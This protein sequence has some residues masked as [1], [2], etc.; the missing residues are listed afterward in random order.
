M[1][2][3]II[4]TLVKEGKYIKFTNANGKLQSANANFPDLPEE[5][6]GKELTAFQEGPKLVEVIWEDR[7]YKPLVQKQVTQ[8]QTQNNRPHQYGGKQQPRNTGNQYQ[9]PPTRDHARAPYN[10]VPLPGIKKPVPLPDIHPERLRAQDRYLPGLLSG[11]IS[12]ELK[13]LTH[14]FFGGQHEA[15]NKTFILNGKAVIPSATLRGLL[16]NAVA[17]VSHGKFGPVDEQ[18]RFYF[19]TNPYDKNQVSYT[20]QAGILKYEDGRYVIYPT[21]FSSEGPHLNFKSMGVYGPS[22]VIENIQYGRWRHGS[23]FIVKPYSNQNKIWRIHAPGVGTK[24]IELTQQDRDTFADD[25]DL[26]STSFPGQDSF[27]EYMNLIACARSSAFHQ[28]VPVFFIQEPVTQRIFIGNTK[29]F[30]LPFSQSLG[31]LIPQ[32]FRMNAANGLDFAEGLFGTLDGPEGKALRGRIRVEN[33]YGPAENELEQPKNLGILLSPKPSAVQMYLEQPQGVRTPKNR[34]R[35]YNSDGSK[36]RGRKLYHHRLF[37]DS[38]EEPDYFTPGTN[39]M[40]KNLN[41]IQTIKPHALFRARI[42]FMNL[43]PEELGALLFVLDLPEGFAHKLGMG[44]PLGLGSFSIQDMKLNIWKTE[45][46]YAQVFSEN[47]E[48]AS[49]EAEDQSTSVRIYKTTFEQFILKEIK[50]QHQ[51][52]WETD[53]MQHYAAILD[54]KDKNTPDW[55]DETSYMG[56]AMKPETDKEHADKQLWKDKAVLPHALYVKNPGAEPNPNSYA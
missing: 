23:D 1:I 49:P 32:N 38:G 19:R 43:L 15:T 53:M 16:R 21:D 29:G 20:T 13:A 10:F 5:A 39:G 55:L 8:Q 11:S 51:N 36:L 28:G 14:A 56:M 12:F 40:Q 34:L 22:G 30:R 17:I 3:K 33:A 54:T 24:P 31:D 48:L 2:K 25:F 7:R 44:K 52:L 27:K 42:H 37:K 35:K 46:L 47:G 18:R 41:Q 4:T 45:T 26:R 6:F 50:S 9:Q